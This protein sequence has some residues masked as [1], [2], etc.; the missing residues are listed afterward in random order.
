M[1]HSDIQIPQHIDS[2]NRVLAT[3]LL[4]SITVKYFSPNEE[5]SLF[6]NTASKNPRVTI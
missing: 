3:P 1:P 2:V 6:K 4:P 5:N